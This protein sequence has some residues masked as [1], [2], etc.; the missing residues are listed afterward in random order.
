MNRFI[1][2][3]LSICPELAIL[4]AHAWLVTVLLRALSTSSRRSASDAASKRR[5]LRCGW[6][7]LALRE[8]AGGPHLSKG[9]LLDR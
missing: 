6:E 7:Q 4:S 9:G 2:L 8:F 1:L 3:G 5:I